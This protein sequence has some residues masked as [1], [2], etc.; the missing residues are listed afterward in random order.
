MKDT[1]KP[2]R[3]AFYDLLNNNLSYNSE[4]VPVYDKKRKVQDLN[5]FFVLFGV[6][7]ETPD[8]VDGAWITDCTIDLEIIYRSHHEVSQDPV[9]DVS[10]Q[11]Y[12]LLEPYAGENGLPAQ[13]FFLIQL[14][15]RQ[16]AVSRV[17]EISTT[18]S[19]VSKIITIAFKMIQQAA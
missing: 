8:P 6:Q 17:F 16:V 5:T 4:L 11:I 15:R 9:D 1:M 3:K 7:Q 10:D 2:A 14:V 19:E 13:P 18:E 12:E